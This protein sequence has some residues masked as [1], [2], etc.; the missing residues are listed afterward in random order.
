MVT[1]DFSSANEYKSLNFSAFQNSIDNKPLEKNPI[2]FWS[3]TSIYNSSTEKILSY[4][5]SSAFNDYNKKKRDFDVEYKSRKHSEHLIYLLER[6]DIVAGEISKAE[7]YLERLYFED[8]EVFSESLQKTTLLSFT[9]KPYVLS[10]LLNAV[11]SLDYEWLN[12]KADL[13]VITGCAHND[14][15]VNEAAIAAAESWGKSCFIGYLEAIR[16]FS[17]DWLENYKNQVLDYLRKQI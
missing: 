8:K 10:R 11:S 16:P 17:I 9:E 6:D 2:S 13:M 14:L 1:I 3:Q 4:E 15:A 5:W 7:M 12:S